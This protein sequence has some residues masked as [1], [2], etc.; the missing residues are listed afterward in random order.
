MSRGLYYALGAL[1]CV[2]LLLNA[3]QWQDR[4]AKLDEITRLRAEALTATIARDADECARTLRDGLQGAIDHDLDAKMR[5]LSHLAQE[6]GQLDDAGFLRRL[7]GM[8][9]GAA[10]GG[11][12]AA[13]EPAGAV[14]D[15]AN[16]AGTHGRQ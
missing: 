15:T 16:A 2:S 1:A 6:S 10:P 12:D 13:G 4:R 9:A 8:L 14:P 7:R 3:A 11:A 5:A